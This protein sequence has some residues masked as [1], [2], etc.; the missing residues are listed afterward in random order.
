MGRPS[1]GIRVILL[2]V[3][4]K[5][6]TLFSHFPASR[7]VRI[8]RRD[9]ADSPYPDVSFEEALESSALRTTTIVCGFHLG[10]RYDILRSVTLHSL[11]IGMSSEL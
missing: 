4:G 10:E 2:L 8:N 11:A 6:G 9:F 3:W 7:T 5:H 1:I